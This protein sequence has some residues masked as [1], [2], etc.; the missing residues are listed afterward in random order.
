MQDNEALKAD[1]EELEALGELADEL[2][3][4]HAETEK[5]LQDELGAY[6]IAW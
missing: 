3:E 1:V 2:E 4:A 6:T 5:Q